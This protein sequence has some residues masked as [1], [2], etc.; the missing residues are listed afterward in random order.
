MFNEIRRGQWKKTWMKTERQR[1]A[2]LEILTYN[3]FYKLSSQRS[4]K[5]F[6]IIVNSCQH[7]LYDPISYVASVQFLKFG[8]DVS[9]H[10]L[11][12]IL[13]AVKAPA[14]VT[15]KQYLDAVGKTDWSQKKHNLGDLGII[16]LNQST[17]RSRFFFS[18]KGYTCLNSQITW[19]NVPFLIY[20]S[21]RNCCTLH[22]N[23]K[24][25]K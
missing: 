17:T 11:R 23:Y 13:V 21:N 6:S 12:V 14:F 3:H 20:I 7:F 15:T 9:F 25:V 18:Q 22:P 10:T 1:K 16:K 19:I 8:E 24:W 5:V 4:P 2:G